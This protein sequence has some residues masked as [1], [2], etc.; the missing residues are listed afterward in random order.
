MGLK[1]I[2]RPSRVSTSLLIING[3]HFIP[4]TFEA[5][6]YSP[7]TI[8]SVR[9]FDVIHAIHFQILIYTSVLRH[10]RRIA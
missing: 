1:Y 6:V 2:T 4:C 8:F 5:D 10:I 3:L 9:G 7:G